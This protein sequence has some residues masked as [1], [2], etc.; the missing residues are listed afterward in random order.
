[1]I[2]TAFI[3]EL[4]S[5]QLNAGL[6]LDAIRNVVTTSLRQWRTMENATRCNGCGVRV[7]A[8]GSM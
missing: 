5:L 7:A 4:E 1:V 6:N 8:V 3:H 2:D